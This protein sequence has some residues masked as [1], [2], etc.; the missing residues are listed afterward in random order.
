MEKPHRRHVFTF[1]PEDNGG[2]ALTVTTDITSDGDIFQ[3]VSLQSYGASASLNFPGWITP[4]RL[5]KLANE[6]ESFIIR[7]NC[8]P[9]LEQCED[10]PPSIQ[11]T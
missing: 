1:N 8:E 2:E 11:I 9:A 7:A 5:R 4:Q 10:C 3:E 6:L